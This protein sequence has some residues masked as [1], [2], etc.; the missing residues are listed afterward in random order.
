MLVLFEYLGL[1][2]STTAFLGSAEGLII[3]ISIIQL[4]I[5]CFQF[6]RKGIQHLL[7]IENWLGI[8][9]YMLSVTFVTRH[10]E[11]ECFCANISIW[12]VGVVSVFLGWLNLIFFLRRLPSTGITISIMYNIFT[13]FLRLIFIAA[14]LIFAFAL[15]FYMLFEIPVS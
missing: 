2:E 15:P 1:E 6:W 11:S 7:D 13:T 10:L 8:L 9:I 5:E 12:G 3:T 14:L 4:L